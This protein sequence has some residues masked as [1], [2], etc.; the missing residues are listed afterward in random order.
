MGRPPAIA[1][2]KDVNGGVANGPPRDRQENPLKNDSTVPPA[3]GFVPIFN[4][5]DLTG[6]TTHSSQPNGWSVKGGLLIGQDAMGYLYTDRDDY[7]DVH[8]RAEVRVDASPA[9]VAF[10]SARR[11]GR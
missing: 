2:E 10:T 6:W 5:R 4:G 9:I 1:G 11:L 3:T 8:V 7:A